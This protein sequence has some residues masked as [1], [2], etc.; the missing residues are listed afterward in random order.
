MKIFRE[1]KQALMTDL[2][3]LTMGAGYFKYKK[4]VVGV[5]ELFVRDLCPRRSYLV[6]AGIL[7]AL[8]YL[9]TLS[10]SD[11]DIEFLKSLKHFKN[12]GDDFFTYLKDFKFTGDVWAAPEGTLIFS[13]EPILQV[14]APLIEAQLIETFLLSIINFETMIAT[15][16]SRMFIS[17]RGKGIIDFGSRRAQG[18]EAGVLAARA[19]YIGGCIGTSNVFA[20]K[21]YN[22]PVYGTIAHSWVMAFEDEMESFK[23]YNSL[24]PENT[25]L[26]IDTFDTVECAKKL[27]SFKGK[28]KGVRIDSGDIDL[29]SRKIRK[30]LDSF[31][32]EDVKIVAS[33]DLNEYVIDKFSHK[34]TPIDFYGV[35]TELV[36]SPDAPSIGGV[37]KLVEIEERGKKRYTLKLSKGKATFPGRKQIFRKVEDGFFKK[38]ILGLANEEKNFKDYIPLLQ[39]VMEKGKIKKCERDLTILRERTIENLKKL[40]TPLKDINTCENFPVEVSDNLKKLQY[41]VKKRYVK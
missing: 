24:F 21:E 37:Y 25:I 28:I 40:K 15:K 12:V 6:V 29:E 7:Q 17:S 16:A 3:Q 10:F 39:K 11:E 20:G 19:S 41:E 27:K 38:D 26:L 35:G 23:K 31:E 4:D 34:K 9:E 1:R 13:N 30:I 2:Y 8:D 22:I 32:M 33:S 14:K 36:T 5:F 18:P